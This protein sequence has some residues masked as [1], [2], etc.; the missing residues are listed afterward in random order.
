MCE[1]YF[2]VIKFNNQFKQ[3]IGF[4]LYCKQYDEKILYLKKNSF[5]GTMN[6]LSGSDGKL[7]NK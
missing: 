1:K 4:Y 3:L 2:S 6:F 7:E 5:E